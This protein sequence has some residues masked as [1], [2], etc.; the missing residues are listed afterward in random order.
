MVSVCGP[1]LL[2]KCMPPTE[3]RVSYETQGDDVH[4]IAS[5][6]NNSVARLLLTAPP[7]L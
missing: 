5:S 6:E 7:A 1:S 4:P 2:K 3:N